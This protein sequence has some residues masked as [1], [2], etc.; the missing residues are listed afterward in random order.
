MKRTFTTL[1]ALATSTGVALADQMPGEAL[2]LLDGNGDTQIS[3]EEFSAS[4][5]AMFAQMD[6]NKSGQIDFSEVE[7]F[8]TRDL[9]DGAD[10]NGNGRLSRAEY[11]AQIRKDFDAADTDAD[12]VLD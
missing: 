4:M 5:G 6:A 12:G 9:F 2:T 8:M 11:D 3:Y 7:T 1:F 10:A